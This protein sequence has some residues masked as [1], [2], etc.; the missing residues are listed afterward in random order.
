MGL[1]YANGPTTQFGPRHR[2]LT[3]R[4]RAEA[5]VLK[6]DRGYRPNLWDNSLRTPTI[7]HWPDRIQPGTVIGR[8]VTFLDWFPTILGPTG[9]ARPEYITL[10][11]RGFVPLL[12]GDKTSWHDD[13]FVKYRMW[14]WNQTAADLRAFRTP[15][16]KL[17]R[18]F[19]NA[20]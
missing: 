12:H 11:G 10:R 19:H 1:Q 16:W 18:D 17:V 13:V 2:W 15:Q 3:R 14:D 4:S 7:I 5:T 6:N 9:I 20:A 8:C